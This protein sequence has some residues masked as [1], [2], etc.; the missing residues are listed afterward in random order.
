MFGHHA[1]RNLKTKRTMH[2]CMQG[3]QIVQK[4]ME[5]APADIRVAW[6]FLVQ[7]AKKV[8]NTPM[9]TK[10]TKRPYDIHIAVK[11]SK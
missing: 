8:K 11:Y 9:T 1:H 10:C 6:F 7:L 2:F 5:L 3:D 4:F